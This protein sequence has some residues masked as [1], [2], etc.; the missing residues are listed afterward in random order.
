MASAVSQDLLRAAATA[1]DVVS[2]QHSTAG[3]TPQ[4][5]GAACLNAVSDGAAAGAGAGAGAG[6]GAGASAAAATGTEVAG[7][8]AGSCLH[9]GVRVQHRYAGARLCVGNKL[10]PLLILQLGAE[11]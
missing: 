5:S 6:G 7:Q 8:H 3:G 11:V 1:L 4:V 10:W 2:A 9:G